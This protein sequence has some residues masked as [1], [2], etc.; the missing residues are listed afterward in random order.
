MNTKTVPQFTLIL[1]ME[2]SGNI[3]YTEEKKMRK[4]CERMT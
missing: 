2:F 3:C 1:D 4:K